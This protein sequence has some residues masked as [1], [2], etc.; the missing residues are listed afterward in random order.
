MIRIRRSVLWSI[1]KCPVSRQ[2]QSDD[3]RRCVQLVSSQ[4]VHCGRLRFF[5]FKP[6]LIPLKTVEHVE[7]FNIAVGTK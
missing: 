2:V 6:E 7:D 1:V 4:C 3:V 5:R